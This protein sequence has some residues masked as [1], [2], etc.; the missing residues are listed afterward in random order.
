MAATAVDV[1]SLAPPSMLIC[2]NHGAS[3]HP[4]LSSGMIFSVNLLGADH[5]EVAQA[6]GGR[7]R[8]EDRFSVGTWDEDPETGVPILADAQGSMVCVKRNALSHGTHE[9]FVG[10]VLSARQ[11]GAIQPMIY[12]NGRYY[13]FRSRIDAV[14]ST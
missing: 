5:E 14:S 12:V 2:V 8:G 3:M 1:F 4:V 10:D 7:L 6:C 11:S 13:T 9:L